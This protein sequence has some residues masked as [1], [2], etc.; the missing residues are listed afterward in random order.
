M[1]R[2]VVIRPQAFTDAA[3][4]SDFIAR[5]S[6]AAAV[7]FLEA[8]DETCDKLGGPVFLGSLCE[9][10]DASQPE[11]WYWPVD[12]FSNHL[13]FFRRNSDRIEILR[14]CHAS[15][16]LRQFFEIL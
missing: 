16:N 2:K 10:D 13:I 8:F 5:N 4:L 9:T 11:L 1:K 12:G 7:H 6:L 14:V 3:E 15:R